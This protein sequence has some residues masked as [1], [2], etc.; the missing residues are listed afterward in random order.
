MRPVAIA[1]HHPKLRI[2]R[3]TLTRAIH[4]LD[5]HHDQL[6]TRASVLRNESEL[7][8]V[9]LDDAALAQLHAEFLDDPTITD[10]ITFEGNPALGTS[11]EICVSADA[12]VRHVTKGP[13]SGTVTAES[14]EPLHPQRIDPQTFS[15]ELAL[16]VIHGW[17]HL[18]GYDDLQPAKKRVMRRAEARALAVLERAGTLPQFQWR[19]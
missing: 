15:R 3:R 7:S 1:S 11:G 8:L 4:V 19:R 17:L 5:S 9:F 10:V 6:A 13:K 2:D 12:A 16:Y 18:A 14:L